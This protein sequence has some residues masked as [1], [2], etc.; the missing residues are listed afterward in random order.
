MLGR[1]TEIDHLEQEDRKT[2]IHAI[3]SLLRDAK[4]DIRTGKTVSFKKIRRDV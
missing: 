4:E 3:D 2:I 1:I